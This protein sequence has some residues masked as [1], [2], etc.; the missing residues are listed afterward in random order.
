MR[1][2]L[3]VAVAA[4]VVAL[5]LP[6]SA[7]A[8]PPVEPPPGSVCTFERGITT[9]VQTLQLVREQ[10][11]RF[12]DPTCPSGIAERRTVITTT[13]T[14]TTVFRGTRMQGEPQTEETTSTTETVSCV[15]A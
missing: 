4:S 13:I 11:V 3:W 8:V 15:A 1:M 10:T 14:V 9:C 2:Q 7:S 12:S 5:G 6:A